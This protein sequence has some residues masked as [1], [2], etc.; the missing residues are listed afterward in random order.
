MDHDGRR[1]GRRHR[2][3]EHGVEQRAQAGLSAV[4]IRHAIG[5]GLLNFPYF[6]MVSSSLK[7]TRLLIAPLIQV[8]F[9]G[10]V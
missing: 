10:W 3:S 6:D 5:D 9:S 4:F 7:F 1:D 2:C 8:S